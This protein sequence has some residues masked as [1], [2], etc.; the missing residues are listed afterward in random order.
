MIDVAYILSMPTRASIPDYRVPDFFLI[1]TYRAKMLLK[2]VL[3]HLS[4]DD[5]HRYANLDELCR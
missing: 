5:S 1:H 2:F 3:N 4:H